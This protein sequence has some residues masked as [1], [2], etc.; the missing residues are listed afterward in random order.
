MRTPF[1]LLLTLA[2]LGLV[3]LS[4]AQGGT[5]T[6]DLPYS[7]RLVDDNGA[8]VVGPVD[9]LIH[10]YTSETG[11]TPMAAAIGFE[12]IPLED[13]VFQVKITLTSQEF[14]KV[15]PGLD[16]ATWI[17]VTD[18]TNGKTYPRQMLGAIPY[19]LKV[20]VDG[21]TIGWNS[22]GELELRSEASVNKVDGESF[23]TK[24]ATAGQVLAWDKTTKTWKPADPAP[25]SANSI[26]GIAISATAPTA[27]Q[28]L[29]YNGTEW[30]AT[31][32]PIGDII[33]NGQTGSVTIGSNNA[34][35]LTLETNNAAALT[36][37]ATGKIGV[38]TT[39]PGAMFQLPAGTIT[40]NSA[41]LKFT[42]GTNLTTPEPGAVEYNGAD[43]FY[44]GTAGIRQKIVGYDTSLSPVSGQVLSWNGSAWAPAAAGGSD[45]LKAPLASPTFTGTV[46]APIIVGGTTTTSTLTYQ[47][48]SGVGAA[49]ADHVFQVGNNGATEAM[50]I[51]NSGNIGV[52]TSTPTAG[53]QLKA[54]AAA[55][56]AAPLKLT[57]GTNLTTAEAGAIE[58]NGTDLFYTDSVAARQKVASYSNLLTPTN[59]QVLSWN[60]SAWAPTASSGVGTVTSITAG[61]GL[62]GGAITSSGTV[63]L[64]DTAVAPGSY[65]RANLTV[66][67]QG[68]LTAAT[69]GSSVNLTSEV[70]GILPVANGGTGLASLSAASVLVTNA[71]GTVTPTSGT[72]A[73]VLVG[74]A[75]TA[76]VFAA[77]TDAQIS[78]SAAV[79]R[80]KLATGTANQVV[81]NDGTGALSS[82]AQ[83]AVSRGGTGAGTAANNFIFAG[84]TSGGPL[85]PAFRAL[86]V[87][88]IPAPA[89]DVS[90]TFAATT[91]SAATIT[92]KAITGYVSG[93]GTVAATDTILGAIQKLNGND[94]ANAPIASPTFTGT[95]TAPAFAG[96]LTGNVT[97]NVSGTA[98]SFTGSLVGDV[99]GTQGATVISAGT[100]TGKPITGYVSGAGSVAATDTILGA[101]QKLDGNDAL[102]APLA[103]PTFTGTVIAPL[104][105]G[106][107][108][109]T[110]ALTYRTTSGVGAAGADHIFQV[111]NN[112]A[113]EAM[114][115]LNSGNVGIG[116]TNPGTALTIGSGQITV[117]NGSPAAPAYAFTNYPTSGFLAN[118]DGGLS[119]V[120]GG[121]TE[122]ALY[123]GSFRFPA[124]STLMDAV[125]G[126]K[127]LSFTSGNGIS[128]TETNSL[129]I[130]SAATGNAPRLGVKGGTDANISLDIASLGTGSVNFTNGN[131]GIGT[132]AP[133]A[134]LQLKA[135][136][137]AAGSAPFKL[138]SGTN[139]TTA[140]AGAIEFNGTDLFYTDNVAARQKIASYSN[141]LTPT[142][143]QVLSWN[144]SAW[145]PT[146]SGGVGT[147][148]SITAGTGLSG[149]AITSSGTV[150]L[151]DT[152]VA[153]GSYTRANLTVDA[154][155]RLTAAASGSSVNLTSE[156]T[157]I[158]P[159]ANGGTGLASLSV[160]SVLVTNAGGTVTPTSGT[161]AQVLVGG[162][163]TAPVFAAITDAQISASAAI[164]RGKVATGTANQVV[165]NDGTGALSSEAQLAVSR[166]GTGAATAGNNLIFAGPTSGGPLAP[167]FRALAASDMPAPGGDVAG[168]FAA[169]TISAATVTGKALTGYV[170]GAGTVAAADTILGAIQKLNGNNALN[171]PIVSPTFTGTVIAPLVEGGTTATSTLTYRTT[172]GVGATGADHIFQVGN[173]GA[174][175]AMRILNS[176][177]VGIG[178]TAPS[179]ELDVVS[180]QSSDPRGITASQ[181][182]AGG[183]GAVF[184]GRKASG[185]PTAPTAVT[186]G[187]WLVGFEA[188]GYDGSGWV[189][190]GFAGFV[191]NGT[192]SAGSVPADFHINTGT[193]GLGVE[194]LRVTSAGNV[195]IGTTAPVAPINVVKD[196]FA[197]GGTLYAVGGFDNAAWSKGIWLG[198]DS[199]DTIGVIGADNSGVVP[200]SLSLVTHNGTANTE[201]MRITGSGNVGIGT[202]APNA[203]LA[204]T[205]ASD[206]NA[207]SLSN[208]NTDATNKGAVITGSRKTNANVPFSGFG[209][210]D[211]GAVRDVYIGGGGWS[212]PDATRILFT[213]AAAYNETNDQGVERMRITAAGYVGIGTTAPGSTLE[214][215][216]Q[217]KITGGT[218]GAGKVLTSDAAGLASWTSP[219]AGSVSG[220]SA[221]TGTQTLANANFAQAWNWDTLSTQNALS[222]GSTSMTSGSLLSLT[223]SF[224][225]ATSTGSML[226]LTAS[227]ASNA[228]T[229]LSITNAGT[230][231]SI[232]AAATGTGTK[233]TLRLQN[234]VTAAN[235]SGAGMLF[236]ANRTTGGL[237]DVAGVA[238]TITDITNGA[239]KGALTFSTASNAAPAERMRIDSTG[240][241]GIG[242]T[243]PEAD[244][245]VI[246][247]GAMRVERAGASWYSA[248][249]IDFSRSRGSVGAK[250]AVAIGDSAGDF[251]F[252]P[253]DGSINSPSASF[254]SIIDGTPVSGSHSPT[255]IVFS[256]LVGNAT[257]VTERMRI[258]SNGNVGIGTTTPT[259]LLSV[260]STSQF[261]VD[262]SG[263][264][265]GKNAFLSTVD[266]DTSLNLVNTSSTTGRWPAITMMNYASTFGGAP[267]FSMNT[268][269]GSNASPAAV[270]NGDLLGNI[271]WSGQ[272]NTTAGNWGVGGSVVAYAEGNFSATSYPTYLSFRTAAVG[273]TVPTD[274]LHIMASG[275]VGI[276]TT[277]PGS[278]L[279][280]VGQVKITGGV[281]GAGKVLTSDAAGLASWTSPSAG[282]VSGLSA[283]TGTQTLANANFAQAWNWDTLST[284]N[285]LSLGSTSMTSGSLLSL[286]DSF[287]SATSTGSMLKLTASGA[288]NA[289]TPLSITNAGTG[290]S[291]DAAATGTGTKYTLRLQ[292]TVTAANNSGAGMLFSANRTTG[293]LTDVAGVA[294]T[295]TDITN[296]AY[297]GA[298]TFSTASNAA[299]AERMRIDSTGNVGIGTTTPQSGLH[300]HSSGTA[301][302][303]SIT[304]T[305]TGS[306]ASDGFVIAF[307]DS[308][309]AAVI[310]R[311]STPL[312]FGTSNA[313]RL[314]IDSAGNV[315]IG[316]TSPSA[317]LDVKGAGSSASSYGFGVRN[318]GDNYS[319]TVRDDG[320]VGVGTTFPTSNFSVSP[321]Q[322][323]TGTA[324][325]STTTVTGSGTIFTAAMVGSQ[326]TF[327][328]GVS[329]GIITA[330]NSNTSLTVSTSQT[331]TSQSYAIN[332]VGL[333]VT[334]T[335]NVGIGTT[336]PTYPLELA[337]VGTGVSGIV[338]IRSTN[339][340]N[341]AQADFFDSSNNLQGFIG[342]A[343][344]SS[345]TPN[346]FYLGTNGASP[347]QFYSNNA[348]GMTLASTGN[349]GIGTT[350]PGSL[351]DIGLAGTTLGTMRLEGNTSGYV[352]LQPAAAAGSWTMT[353]PSGAGTNG[354]VLSTNGSGVTTWAAPG[355]GAVDGLTDAY[356][357]Y[358][359]SNNFTMG[360]ASAAALTVGA[361]TNM[362]VGPGAGGT[363]AS[364]TTAADNNLAVGFNALGSLTSGSA[365]VAVGQYALAA[366]TTGNTNN[367]LGYGALQFNTTGG[368]NTAMGNWAIHNNISGFGNVGIG[369]ESLRDSNANNNVAIGYA[370]LQ[371]ATGGNNT[372]IGTYAGD[373]VGAGT[374]NIVIGYNV[375]TPAAGM[376]NQLNIGNAIFGDLSTDKIGIGTIAPSGS[377][378]VNPVQ[379]TSGT[380]SQST[381]AI[382]GVGTT[383]TAAM[384]GS[385]FVFANGVS[386]GTITAFGS[387]TT[388][389]VSVSQTVAGQ[390]YSINYSGLNVTS[391]GAVGIGTTAPASLLN[392]VAAPTASANYGLLSLG[393]GGLWN[394]TA[395]SFIGS[396]NGTELAVN[397]ASGYTGNL[398]D[399]QVAGVSKFKVDAT[400]NAVAA[401]AVIQ[402]LGNSG[403]IVSGTTSCAGQTGALTRD[404]S[405]DLYLCK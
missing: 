128:N 136:A 169:T 70:T 177:N 142:S 315:G 159:I 214:V 208:T 232:D 371:I 357:D 224:N 321:P 74:G 78:A 13:G 166:G 135:G 239:Y 172:S 320:N 81:I 278:A 72:S 306:T 341:Y 271:D 160:A 86:D 62:S 401:G 39:A 317:A 23:V 344:A 299:P 180:T 250:T 87:S 91:I 3:T 349:V 9:M 194:R 35:A 228:A 195:G 269:R 310:N 403:A 295:I 211:S 122:F 293:G 67:A 351:L 69:S 400:G 231:F 61:T 329:A 101:I 220:L 154:Q 384:V 96:P 1:F 95:V 43:L 365:I 268:S 76:P 200:S 14:H 280:V 203:T 394:G 25:S 238:G 152:A 32:T 10:F 263:N 45:P 109:T 210:F 119:F 46:I 289:A 389:T 171:A 107:T 366:N 121:A 377:L 114:R 243:S 305:A 374:G 335:G 75:G 189:Y 256:T 399:M 225:S 84:P 106:G 44:T 361:I 26:Q 369:E 342:W 65:T 110:S 244:L 292:N 397:A 330:R 163:G 267:S 300:V 253:Y 33:N 2:T 375:D 8:P 161:S 28:I 34:A 294:G 358:G 273:S 83:L 141:L 167:A 56:G 12:S 112:G 272:F 350:I 391:T 93:A 168:T 226:K 22:A 52:G 30:I 309:G 308:L 108:T 79:A 222:L 297:K 17:Q 73:Q 246:G 115:I 71:G 290:F 7:G 331:V 376:S 303:I 380:A 16:Q 283:A 242:T 230:G 41:P 382:T 237:T 251:F 286:T 398:A 124:S 98:G 137:A 313:E 193:S 356:T 312:L 185:I 134:A 209:T 234:T 144:G 102:K 258:S 347:V 296:G 274:R 77:I 184:M 54:G 241:V 170:S 126:N 405:G 378:S 21:A 325:Q 276:G 60:G 123:G 279:E 196:G 379:Y 236:S 66:D 385:Q 318:S 359:G 20:P 105:E 55:A 127:L 151:A 360:R 190:P 255:A 235:N 113:T 29:S 326:L 395:N 132:T 192:I 370:A 353:L 392:V 338:K 186:N 275:N 215:A 111:G 146:A 287:N 179:T 265:N 364:M 282:S 118:G 125:S 388:L 191:T 390:A 36:I 314:R 223:D 94:A 51:L 259:N 298:L 140:E 99:T 4:S 304:D 206:F 247:A 252:R 139:L 261:N 219:S 50:R 88:D 47:A 63:A 181:Y 80:G 162:A 116:T 11:R 260:G 311:E 188:G 229:P 145:A 363:S 53:L 307:Q 199:S 133:T 68:R 281:P 157:G 316:T 340:A 270:L 336:N 153:P 6:I 40:A 387:A 164:T 19:A 198:Y 64:A 322:Y 38:G 249:S 150:A 277:A 324:S 381:T 328:N 182:S 240:N 233:Y 175:E 354:Y 82:E 155:G 402:I 147:V 348:V 31:A 343:N 284:Q 89:G 104:V 57:S 362:F 156:V 37:D 345:A 131:V 138:T 120:L 355:G 117:P 323:S 213:T 327:A 254:G 197:M 49:G 333:N 383:F 319:F 5:G 148:T 372:A 288:S 404:S 216:G 15:F 207:I 205:S 301:S 97:G 202:T 367:A 173:N 221:A 393:N 100:V 302:T 85:A 27:G 42:S 204:V 48:T 285:A 368:G 264:I 24:G 103:S 291:I 346:T 90:G 58:F 386:A 149:G 212:R 178:T 396:A 218:P 176:G 187:A 59:G 183:Y 266:A 332:Y 339:I 129:D 130:K 352:Q 165:I 373:S 174:T 262:G 257:T 92:G 217:V 18:D 248:P 158:L 201:K 337:A 245:H 143:G 227:G 334:S